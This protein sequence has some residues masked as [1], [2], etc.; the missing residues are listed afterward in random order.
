M[1]KL[2][3]GMSFLRQS[4][5][6][7]SDGTFFEYNNEVE[8]TDLSNLGIT[9]FIKCVQTNTVFDPILNKVKI[10]AGTVIETNVNYFLKTFKAI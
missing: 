3:I 9:G 8:I 1:K 10:E 5:S 7:R 6:L 4:K 2:K